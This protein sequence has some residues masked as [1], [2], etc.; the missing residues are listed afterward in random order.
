MQHLLVHPR[1]IQVLRGDVG[2]QEEEWRALASLSVMHAVVLERRRFHCGWFGGSRSVMFEDFIAGAC[3]LRRALA[4]YGRE[5]RAV[6][7]QTVQSMV[8]LQYSGLT[9]NEW[10]ARVL[11]AVLDKH[12]HRGVLN[13]RYEVLPGLALAASGRS[14]TFMS[15]IVKAL[16]LNGNRDRIEI[17]GLHQIVGVWRCVCAP[18][19]R[20]LACTNAGEID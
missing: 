15:A 12:L 18:C 19:V 13:S 8:A 4:M 17:L 11:L 7:F 2:S 14:S 10:D 3:S 20:P 1:V 5:H 9:T 6:D 16:R